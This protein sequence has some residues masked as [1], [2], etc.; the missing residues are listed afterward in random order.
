M[1]PMMFA[2]NALHVL[3]T[4]ADATKLLQLTLCAAIDVS[5]GWLRM[6]VTAKVAVKEPFAIFVALAYSAAD[7]HLAAVVAREAVVQRFFAPFIVLRLML[8][9]RFLALS[10]RN[11][12]RR[13][14]K[15]R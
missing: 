15:T 12:V 2:S 13:E 6:T 14:R 7:I 3:A 8:N 5:A 9:L 10:S 4:R 11:L 1:A